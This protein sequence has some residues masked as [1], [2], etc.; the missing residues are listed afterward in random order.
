VGGAR[1]AVARLRLPGEAARQQ[2]DL[3]DQHADTEADN[4]CWG[5]KRDFLTSSSG[6]GAF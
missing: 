5:S 4:L 3:Q 1:E 2:E 6:C